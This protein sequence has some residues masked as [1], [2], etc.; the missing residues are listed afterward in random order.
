MSGDSINDARTTAENAERKPSAEK[1]MPMDKSIG[2]VPTV[3]SKGER[4]GRGA[5]AP[6]DMIAG[7]YMVVCKLG[8]GGMGVVYKCFD[9]VGGVKVAVKC[10]PS[11]VSRN[12]DEMEDIRANYQLVRQLRHQN[13]AGATS[14]EMDGLTGDYYL[15]MDLVS[16][17]SLKRWMRRN[18]N[19]GRGVKI[20]ILRQVAAALDYAHARRV[21]HRDIKPENVMVD[22][23]GGVK[24]LDFGLAAKI[25]SSQSRTS[26]TVSSRSGTWGYMSPEQWRAKPQR[27]Q[28]D[29]YSFGVMA[30]WMFARVLPFEGDDPMVLG[31]AVLTEPVEP[32]AGLPDY[33]NAALV[34]A[35]AKK[36]EDRFASCGEVVVALEKRAEPQGGRG[37]PEWGRLTPKGVRAT[38]KVGLLK[39]KVVR[40]I[41]QVTPQVVSTT[42]QVGGVQISGTRPPQYGGYAVRKER[43][44]DVGKVLAA[45]VMFAVAVGIGYYGRAKYDEVVANREAKQAEERA[46]AKDPPVEVPEENETNEPEE[47]AQLGGDVAVNTNKTTV[48]TPVEQEARRKEVAALVEL[49]NGITNKVNDAKGKIDQI[50][51]YRGDP[52]RWFQEHI[53][54][55]DRNWDI[56]NGVNKIPQT[57]DEARLS[58][59]QATEAVSAIESELQWLKANKENRDV[60]KAVEAAIVREIVPELML[61]NASNSVGSVRRIYN[62][63]ERLRRK[64]N[65]ALSNGDFLS[66]K[67]NLHS[68]KEKLYKAVEEAKKFCINEHFKLAEKHY[69]DSLWEQCTNECGMV[70]GWDSS[71]AKAKQLKADAENR[72]MPSVEVVIYVKG[73]SS[74]LG[75]GEKVKIGDVLCTTP[76]KW[77]K[78]D[79]KEGRTYGSQRVSYERGGRCYFGKLDAFTGKPGLQ[80]M[81]VDM[82]EEEGNGAQHGETRTITLPG[83][84]TMEMIYVE[85]RSFTMG[86]PEYELGR[87]R[88][89]EAQQIVTL[90][91]GFWLGKFEVTQRQWESVMGYNRSCFKGPN[92]PVENIT[93]G[94]CQE[95]IQKVNSQFN[96]GARFPTEAEWECA[97]RAGSKGAYGGTGRLD[98]M[99]WHS[100]NSGGVTHDVGNREPNQW[101]FCDM[102]GNVWEYC[103]N[104]M[105]RGGCLNNMDKFCRSA[106][107]N[108]YRPNY[109]YGREVIGFRLC[110]STVPNE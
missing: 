83:G 9:R 4:G 58:L 19:A 38:P 20:A 40:V 48:L 63:G 68:A 86:S 98:E 7:R 89:D 24:V 82:T 13:I 105:L 5:F 102:H 30:Y 41:P 1:G 67:E 18:P 54:A 87:D 31:Q 36:P 64:G 37:I 85:P 92:R 107:R 80:R 76:I 69:M 62:E 99:G 43:N 108:R 84:E 106:F 22:D 91:R 90:T 60:A 35:L 50:E 75:K 61:F 74:P 8:E 53:N 52:D 94:E 73:D 95:F 55:A 77:G 33:M 81:R 70:L 66:A 11:E 110:C 88:N 79:V 109:L 27:E 32:I 39:P 14:L 46:R 23:E 96:Y 2:D 17:I 10:L 44:Y 45:V 78:D 15:V 21:I 72:L 47:R 101:G 93:W 57:V 42:P 104:K 6:G 51:P 65:D 29:V 25:R 56:A 26:K 100:G 103:E 97:C 49:C 16:G 12:E 71:N 59:T 3:R 28:S 34:K